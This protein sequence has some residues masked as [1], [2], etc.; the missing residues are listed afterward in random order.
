MFNQKKLKQEGETIFELDSLQKEVLYSIAIKEENRSN[1]Y[2]RSILMTADNLGYIEPV[3]L[4]TYLKS[5]AVIPVPTQK[6]AEENKLFV[7]P[8]PTSGY[9]I[10]RYELDNYYAD[11]IIQLTDINGRMV[12]QYS[13]SMTRDYLVVPT[14]DL[15]RGNYFIKL[16]LNG[17][18]VGV[19]KVTIQ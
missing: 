13:T 4:P 11:A 17:K 7:Y 6:P 9:F 8:N 14:Q 16:I 15:V 5:S 10:I 12:K 1:A 18:E 2:A 19:Q 3:L